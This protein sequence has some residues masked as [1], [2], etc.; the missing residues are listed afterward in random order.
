MW[1]YS[2]ICVQKYIK[3][4]AREETNPDEQSVNSMSLWRWRGHILRDSPANTPPYGPSPQRRYRR[5]QTAM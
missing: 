2:E 4:R 1:V 3:P 5:F